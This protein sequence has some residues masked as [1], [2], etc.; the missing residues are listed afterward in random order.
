[1]LPLVID[2]FINTPVICSYPLEDSG[3]SFTNLLFDSRRLSGLHFKLL[4]YNL[5]SM[6]FSGIV[7][8]TSPGRVETKLSFL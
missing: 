5:A 4:R 3:F 7:S 6:F 1:M 8:V 2:Y